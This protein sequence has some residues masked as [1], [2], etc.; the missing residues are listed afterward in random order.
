MEPLCDPRAL[1]RDI[2]AAA[3]KPPAKQDLN[4]WAERNIVFGRESPFPGPYRRATIPAAE[5]IL[6][7]LSP[8]HPARTVTIKASAQF[9]KTTLGQIFIG[10][11]MD[12]DPCDIGYTHPTHDNA[13][14]WARRKWKV[15]RR[16]S[17]ALRRVFGEAK[18]RDSSDT[19]LYQ[20]HRLGLGSLQISGAN[21]AAS[22]SMASW[23]KQVQ[24]D[25]AKWETNIGG[26]PERQA[27]SR[28]SAFDWAKILKISTPLF[29]KTCRITRAYHAGTQERFHVPCPHCEHLAPFE[30]DNF[31]AS[32]DPAAPEA[33]HFTCVACGGV[34]EHKHKRAIVARG[35]W[36]ADNPSAR[37][38]SFHIWRAYSPFR[39]WGSIAREWIAAQGDPLAE[40][41][42]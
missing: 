22:L 24:D 41:A 1:I 38:P 26:D 32:I 30:W 31:R 37:E 40:Q 27:D 21:S 13:L 17:S 18:S 15:M 42:F 14:R 34:I 29:A 35:H 39:D 28:S 33:A 6:A 20:E 36:I 9:F 8:D 3:F 10:G 23:P 4:D 2:V 19:T 25:L 5:R 16:Q 7:C 11:S 12:L